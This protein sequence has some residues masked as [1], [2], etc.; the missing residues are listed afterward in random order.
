MNSKIER[1][2]V[3][4]HEKRKEKNLSQSKLAELTGLSLRSIQRIENAEVQPREYSKNAL[5]EVLEFSEE[6]NF[7]N[8]ETFK[9]SLPKKVILSLSSAICIPL[10]ALAFIAQSATFP[11][12]QF[13]NYI[14]WFFIILV[15]TSFQWGI[16]LNW[17]KST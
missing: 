17:K 1:F 3:L 11:E 12:T 15:L 2:A 5:S 16:W 6:T 14:F 10:L 4:V 8:K 9:S 13:E 7:E